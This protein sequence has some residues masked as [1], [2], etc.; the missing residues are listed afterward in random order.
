VRVKVF[1][2]LVCAIILSAIPCY[3]KGKQEHNSTQANEVQFSVSDQEIAICGNLAFTGV[4]EKLSNREESVQA[5]LKDAARRLSFFNSISGYSV[6]QEQSRGG[7]FDFYINS[8]RHLLYD[9]KLEEYLDQLIFDPSADVFEFNNAVFVITHVTSDVSMPL[10]R[11]HSWKN[12]R[13]GWIDTPP[14]EIEGFIAG[15]GFSSRLSSHSDTVIKSY[16]NAVIG[17]IENINIRFRGKQQI[18]QNNSGA[19]DYYL[20]SLNETGA[21]GELKNFY[22]IESW[23]DPKNLSVWTLAVA[24]RM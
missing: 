9:D 5:A 4:S 12:E 20:D 18:Y 21:I 22:I 13:P 19:F 3:G 14:S 23:T 7:T 2:P 1:Y 24:K 10:F 16:E 11:G 15:T 6:S 8:D 17:I